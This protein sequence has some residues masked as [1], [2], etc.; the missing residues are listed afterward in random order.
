MNEP[1]PT[2]CLSFL[3]VGLAFFT[4]AP[5]VGKGIS[6]LG[7]R[8]MRKSNWSDLLKALAMS[9][10]DSVRRLF[11]S[12]MMKARA[13]TSAMKTIECLVLLQGY[14]Y[15]KETYFRKLYRK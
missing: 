6:S 3:I 10:R 15:G 5:P 14:E 8:S 9:E 12:A 2:S 7:T 1:R 11:E 13:V 4:A